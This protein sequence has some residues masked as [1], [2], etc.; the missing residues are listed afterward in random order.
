MNGRHAICMVLL[1]SDE[2]MSMANNITRKEFREMFKANGI[3]DED[4][5]HG[6]LKSLKGV[7]YNNQTQVRMNRR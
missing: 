3:T 5:L 6:D 2:N 7:L 4:L 1:L